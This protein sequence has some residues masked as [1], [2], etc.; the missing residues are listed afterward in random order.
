MKLKMK[1]G[2]VDDFRTANWVE[3]VKYPEL[4]YEKSVE[5]L[6]IQ[7]IKDQFQSIQ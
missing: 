6:N 2:V 1:L 7:V 3:M 4:V 5:L